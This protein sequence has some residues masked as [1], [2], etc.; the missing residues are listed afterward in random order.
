LSSLVETVSAQLKS[1]ML[2]KDAPR[3]SALRMVRAAF[4]EL[5]KDGKGEVTDDRCVESLR[6]LRKQREDSVQ[7]Y[8][9]AGR[10]D[11]A[12]VERSEMIIIDAL[13]PALANEETTLGWVRAAIR[14]S[15]AS[16]VREMGKAMGLLMKEHK[17]DVDAGLARQLLTRELGG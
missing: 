2:A 1:A 14:D 10:T 11:L 8:E 17:T 7:S 15:G 3:T 4:I 9:Q 6:R 12:D 13:L 16:S 5:A